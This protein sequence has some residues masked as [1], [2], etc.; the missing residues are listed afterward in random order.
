ML[1]TLVMLLAAPDG[2]VD[3]KQQCR[4]CTS[5]DSK[6]GCSNIGIACQPSR[7]ICQPE[8]AIPV[9]DRSK[10]MKAHVR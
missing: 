7:R 4:A 5:S 9:S 8:I 10:A 6:Q 1:L 3:V 2:C